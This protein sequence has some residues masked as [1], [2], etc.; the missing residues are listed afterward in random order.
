MILDVLS[1]VPMNFRLSAD[2][3]AYGGVESGYR[4]G[5]DIQDFNDPS[6]WEISY[7]PFVREVNGMPTADTRPRTWRFD[8]H[9]FY[10][11]VIDNSGYT[12]MAAVTQ[13]ATSGARSASQ[14]CLKGMF[15]AREIASVS[16]R[17]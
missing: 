8:S 9:T 16:P 13:A 7:T 11:E 2:A 6:Q 15:V 5:W 10:V 17:D 3:S 1:G 4:Y 14:R 12:S